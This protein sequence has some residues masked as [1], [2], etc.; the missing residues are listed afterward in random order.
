MNQEPDGDF[1]D[2][3]EAEGLQRLILN[4]PKAWTP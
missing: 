4:S 2:R 1:M 3:K